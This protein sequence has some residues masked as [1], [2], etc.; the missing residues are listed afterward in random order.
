MESIQR[1]GKINDIRV[2]LEVQ[3]GTHMLLGEWHGESW[4]G[5]LCFYRWGGESALRNFLRKMLGVVEGDR[6]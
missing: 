6:G 4:I 3:H 2:I 5:W 1:I